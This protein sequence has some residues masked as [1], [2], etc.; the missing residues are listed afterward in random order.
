MQAIL[1]AVVVVFII[2]FLTEILLNKKNKCET[3]RAFRINEDYVIN[4]TRLPSGADVNIN[5]VEI[6]D[7][8]TLF[9]GCGQD[10]TNSNKL[11]SQLY[12]EHIDSRVKLFNKNDELLYT[13][14]WTSINVCKGL[15]Q[16]DIDY[17]GK[18]EATKN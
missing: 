18:N 10:I 2:I 6:I 7:T 4:R 5:G 3:A 11:L 9:D 14:K 15:N 12:G 13:R 1:I 16:D 17:Y 8:S